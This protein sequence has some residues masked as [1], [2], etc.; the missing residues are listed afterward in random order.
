[1]NKSESLKQ[2]E[3]R[4]AYTLYKDIKPS[5]PTLA[6]NIPNTPNNTPDTTGNP[7]LNSL[8][9]TYLKKE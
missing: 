2:R 7:P 4:E 3:H 8:L 9:Q 5:V 1:M 6:S